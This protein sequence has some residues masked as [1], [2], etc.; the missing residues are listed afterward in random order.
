M[1]KLVLLW[2]SATFLAGIITAGVAP[3]SSGWSL[4]FLLAITLLL[5]SL[6]KRKKEYAKRFLFLSL[7]L[8]SFFSGA[9]HYQFF[10][11]ESS[12]NPFT[13]SS[14][15]EIL[16][17]QGVV[18]EPTLDSI[19]Y[20]ETI[21]E[22]QNILNSSGNW[23]PADGKVR[24]RLPESFN[25]E[26]HT[27]L[28][29]EG[30]LSSAVDTN[31]KAHTSWLKCNGID[32]QM[33]YPT[34]VKETPV[35]KFSFMGTLYASR[36]RAYQI[37]QS[38]MPFPENELLAG[39]LLG[40]E[41]R[42]PDYLSE[43]YR[44]TGTAHILAI[45]GFNIAL[46]SGIISKFFNR[47]LPYRTGALVSIFVIALYA[48]FVGA[49]PSVLRAALMGILFIPAHLIGRRIIGIHTLAITAA[50]MALFNPYLLWDVGFQLSICATF[51][52]LMFTDF[53]TQKTDVL[54]QRSSLPSKEFLLGF[55]KDFLITTFSA[56][57]AAFPVLISHFEEFSLIS[58]LVNLLI[59]PLQPA[60]MVLGGT[61]LLAGL[62][63]YPLGRLVG[64]MAWFIT[65]FNNQIVLLFSQIPL[66]LA[67]NHTW[68]FWISL[69]LNILLV[70]LVL[71]EQSK[72]RLQS[73]LSHV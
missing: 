16:T 63:F 56:Q 10:S 30:T 59:L 42:I 58:P 11:R 44:L 41:S 3:I 25:F 28:T 37:L 12:P 26:Y 57:V 4:G 32:Y 6:V 34:V 22:L 72:S 38:I 67:F 18:V 66:T 13:K 17:L 31:S 65:A 62:L 69:A 43:A 68:G 47:T 20:G 24:I 14:T 8:L 71:R 60:I 64:L 9:L 45:S 23:Q 53:F 40:I 50:C 61:A 35:E 49:Q 21:V 15:N 33:F 55:I 54:L 70:F 73:N 7:L 51:G 36:S 29:L 27:A 5:Y 2:I 46:I 48:L 1:P 52:I 39:I 19:Q